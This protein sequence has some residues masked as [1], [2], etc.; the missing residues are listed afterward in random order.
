[1]IKLSINGKSLEVINGTT[2]IEAAESLNIKIPTLCYLKEYA[3]NSTCM[4]CTVKEVN[5]NRLL[6]ACAALAEDG[7]KIE[8]E[9]NELSQFRKDTLELLFSEHVGECVAPCELGCP[10]HMQ[11]PRMMQQISQGEY[12][13]ALQTVKE[14]IAL[15]GVLGFVCSAPCENACRR[16][17]VDEPARICVLKRSVAQLDL[18]ENKPYLP[19][20][21]DSTGKSIAIIG[22][23]PTGLAAAYYAAQYGH[24]IT[25]FD[26]NEHPGGALRYAISESVL[27]RDILEAEVNHIL[28][29]GVLFK[30]DIVIGKSITLSKLLSDY[31]GVL[32]AAGKSEQIDNDILNLPRNKKGI[33]INKQT[34]ETDMPGIFAAGDCVTSRGMAIQAVADGKGAAVAINTFLTDGKAHAK[35]KRVRSRLGRVSLEEINQF[36]KVAEPDTPDFNDRGFQLPDLDQITSLSNTCLQC[37]CSTHDICKLRM[38]ADEYGA[39]TNR[40]RFTERADMVR[41]TDHSYVLYEPGKCIKCG[42]CIA[43]AKES[44]E[45]LGLTYIGRGFDV[46]VA[47][48]YGESLEQGLQKAA[49]KCAS[50]CP[51]GAIH[52]RNRLTTKKS[53]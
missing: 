51:T 41:I 46:K 43:A 29:I 32:I 8:T 34:F 42:L 11:I 2:L 28:S 26:K 4:I 48:P 36:L 7:M 52:K 45:E 13:N 53:E 24:S 33:K 50:V 19:E 27:P 10:A 1:M 35:P 9:S 49:D 31:D 16:S 22:S 30:G 12:T 15:P 44:G 5:G 37:G 18:D 21:G 14:D 38:Y 25:I 39:D 3:P 6:P 47:V 40:Y 20:I 23:G 17:K